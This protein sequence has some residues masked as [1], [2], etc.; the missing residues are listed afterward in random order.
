MDKLS[1][2]VFKEELHKPSNPDIKVHNGNFKNQLHSYIE[3]ELSGKKNKEFRKL[4][5]SAIEFVENAIDLM[6]STT[7]KLNAK[8][9]L[10]EM[11]VISTISA[12]SIVKLIDELD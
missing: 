6:N 4:A 1:R 8:E 9:H 3:I 5:V 11:S 2:E 7:H 10:A 12:V